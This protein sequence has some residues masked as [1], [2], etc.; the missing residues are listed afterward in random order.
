MADMSN[1]LL[2]DDSDTTITFLPVSNAN[3]NLVWRA[4]LIGVPIDGQARLTATWEKLKSGDYRLSAKLEVPVLETIGSAAATGYVAAAKTAYVMVGIFT[5][6]APARSTAA[7]RANVYRMMTHL[8]M[9]ASSTADTGNSANIV[10]SGTFEGVGQA[11]V[12]PYSFINVVM[13]S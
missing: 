4:N 11:Q 3:Q 10:A 12:L 13:P 7:D 6:F 1:I 2:Q 8:M 9:G 5:M